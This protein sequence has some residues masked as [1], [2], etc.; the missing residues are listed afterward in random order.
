MQYCWLVQVGPH[1]E[2]QQSAY[3]NFIW[4]GALA[5]VVIAPLAWL[6]MRRR[7]TTTPYLRR[8]FAS[9]LRRAAQRDGLER[10]AAS[11]AVNRG[12]EIIK[13]ET[14]DLQPMET[15]R[16][17]RQWESAQAR[18]SDDPKGAVTQADALLSALMKARG[19]PVADFEKHA[20]DISVDHPRLVDN[21]R[22]ARWLVLRLHRGGANTGDL[23]TAM[24]YYRSL[25]KEL[26]HG[27]SPRQQREA[28]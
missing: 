12:Q 28:A 14:R 2:I 8:R 21:Y 9:V 6:Y 18:F 10:R 5:I 17:A 7:G 13:F 1:L 16:F 15:D 22:S 20:P 25:F 23:K 4:L 24:I 19:Y 3:S 26:M 11:T 27:Q